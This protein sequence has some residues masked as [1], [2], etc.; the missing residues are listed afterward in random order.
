MER[1]ETGQPRTS[2]A[3]LFLDREIFIN[4]STWFNIGMS[5]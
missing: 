2:C 4:I 1:E 5:I 3:I